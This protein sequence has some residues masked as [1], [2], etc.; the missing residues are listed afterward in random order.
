[1]ASPGILKIDTESKTVTVSE[2]S[3][4]K[5]ITGT[6]LAAVLGMNPYKTDFDVWADMVGAIKSDFEENAYTLA[7]KILEP[8]IIEY[9]KEYV[10]DSYVSAGEYHKT[11]Y[12]DVFPDEKIFGGVPDLYKVD[13]STN[14]IVVVNDIKTTSNMQKW[15]NGAPIEYQYQVALYAYLHKVDLFEITVMYIGDIDIGSLSDIMQANVSRQNCMTYKYS[16]SEDLPEFYD[17]LRKAEDWYVKHIVGLASP[18]Y[19]D[20]PKD[21]EIIRLIQEYSQGV[22]NDDMC[23]KMESLNYLMLRKEYLDNLQNDITKKI[24]ELKKFMKPLVSQKVAKGVY[25][26]MHLTLTPKST[27]A[28]D[29]AR[30]KLDGV[31]DTYKKITNSLVF[32]VSLDAPAVQVENKTAI[33]LTAS[34]EVKK[35]S[36]KVRN[37]SVSSGLYEILEAP[38]RRYSTKNYVFCYVDV[39]SN[40]SQPLLELAEIQSYGGIVVYSKDERMEEPKEVEGLLA[41]ALKELSEV[42]EASGTRDE[43]IHSEYDSTR[44]FEDE[45]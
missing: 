8:R 7:G 42:T 16:I 40:V 11:R 34:G 22:T 19:T 27:E 38:Y 28:V 1:M 12:W 44:M 18:K 5:K 4:P 25:G 13:K 10:D 45:R 6:R 29:T 30:M 24:T 20:F 33:V 3:K 15:E 31:Y 43:G 17:Q 9:L 35:E 41:E 32:N 39:G 26:N 21:Q 14:K 37:G 2:V 36:L 23:R